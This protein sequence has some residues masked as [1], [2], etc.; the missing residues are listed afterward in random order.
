MDWDATLTKIILSSAFAK[1]PTCRKK[2]FNG[3]SLE[4]GTTAL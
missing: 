1:L 3:P 4:N 2:K